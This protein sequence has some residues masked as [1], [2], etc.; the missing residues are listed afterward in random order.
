MPSIKMT[1]TGVADV[2]RKLQRLASKE[3]KKVIRKA[4][5]PA[6][7]PV[8]QEARGTA[9]VKTGN[10]RRNIKIRALPRSRRFFGSRVTSGAG[11]NA[12]SGDGFYG[13]FLE[14]GTTRI[15]ARNFMKNAANRKKTQALNIYKAELRKGLLNMVKSG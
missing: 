10:L 6:L 4:T 15:K 8:L 7:K 2:D 9:P 12:N 11:R 1:S 13:A 14:F 3:A 5:R